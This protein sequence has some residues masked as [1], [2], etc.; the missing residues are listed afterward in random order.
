MILK[1][2]TRDVVETEVLGV[3]ISRSG[4][5][6][7]FTVR[8]PEYVKVEVDDVDPYHNLVRGTT[9]GRLLVVAQV[10][11]SL[12]HLGRDFARQMFDNI[13]LCAIPVNG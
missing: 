6:I 8:N 2:L 9:T 7:A 4:G 11:A 3:A 5:S 13:F 10:V 12:A 1:E